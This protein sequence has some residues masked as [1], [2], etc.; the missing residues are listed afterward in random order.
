VQTKLALS[1]QLHPELERFWPGPISLFTNL[2]A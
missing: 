2:T 1:N